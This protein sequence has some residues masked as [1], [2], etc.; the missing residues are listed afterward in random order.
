MRRM[1]IIADIVNCSEILVSPVEVNAALA[2]MGLRIDDLHRAID[3]GEIDRDSCTLF[4][5][6]PDAGNRAHGTTVRVLREIYIPQG[7]T[8]RNHQNLSTIISPND[9]I[10]IAVG[11][12]DDAAG[13]SYRVP[14]SKYPKGDLILSEVEANRRQLSL[15]RS[16]AKRTD[17]PTGRITWVLLRRR[18]DQIVHCELS[19]PTG[20]ASDKRIIFEGTRI[21]LPDFDLNPGGGIRSRDDGP[22]GDVDVQ[23]LR[24]QA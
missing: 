10:E 14:H 15:F 6:P 8:F 12:G 17:Q 5:P 16:S 21:I 3:A 2:I 23:I 19:I 7:W 13:N 18:Q 4:N 22:S 11:S 20:V 9:E 24:R 1:T